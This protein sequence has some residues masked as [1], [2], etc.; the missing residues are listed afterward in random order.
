MYIVELLNGC[1][2]TTLKRTLEIIRLFVDKIQIA[3]SNLDAS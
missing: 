1:I 2:P 3:V